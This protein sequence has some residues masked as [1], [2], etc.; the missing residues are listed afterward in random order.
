M[1]SDDLS[2]DQIGTLR[3]LLEGLRKDLEGRLL[4]MGEQSAPVKLDQQSVGRLSRM[5]AM[6]HQQMARASESSMQA[7]LKRVRLGLRAIEDGEY[8][9]CRSCDEPISF[10][11]LMVRPDTPLCIRCQEQNET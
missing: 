9:Y 1:H 10:A 6:Q 2:P 3:D 11:R 4:R 5:D 7:H 8:G